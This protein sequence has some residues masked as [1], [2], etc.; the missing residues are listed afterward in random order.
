MCRL[1]ELH[2]LLCLQEGPYTYGFC[3]T[4]KRNGVRYRFLDERDAVARL[5]QIARLAVL[6]PDGAE[7]LRAGLEDFHK[8]KESARAS[9]RA[10]LEARIGALQGKLTRAFEALSE[11]LVD[12]KTYGENTAGWRAEKAE[13]EI[14]LRESPRIATRGRLRRPRTLSNSP[15]ARNYYS[16][17]ETNPSARNW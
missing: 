7:I 13:P 5:E 3:G 16:K 9:R 15:T 10:A 2:H 11:G 6:P 14:A 1:R 17:P 12:A 8:G 4:C